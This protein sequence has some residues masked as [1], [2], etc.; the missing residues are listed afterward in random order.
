MSRRHTDHGYRIGC[1]SA[2]LFTCIGAVAGV[3]FWSFIP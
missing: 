3:A 1:G 2:L